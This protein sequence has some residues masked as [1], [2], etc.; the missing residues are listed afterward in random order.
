MEGV[1][2]VSLGIVT[3]GPDEEAADLGGVVD[4]EVDGADLDAGLGIDGAGLGDAV[5]GAEVGGDVAGAGLEVDA[6]DLGAAA[7]A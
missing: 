7:A 6:A 5:A 2:E 1:E 3:E 4:V